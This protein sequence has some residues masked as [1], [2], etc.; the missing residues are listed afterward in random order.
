MFT[1]QYETVSGAHAFQNFDSESWQLLV[2]HLARFER[3]I[4]AV[5][6]RD[7]PIT[8]AVR[9]SMMDMSQH[10]NAHFSKAAKDFI[11]CPA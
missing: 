4:M 11:S 6:E 7:V 1:I 10:Q 5:F 2:G 8:K 3:P 9:K